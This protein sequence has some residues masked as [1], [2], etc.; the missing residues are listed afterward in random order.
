MQT[1][2]SFPFGMKHPQAQPVSCSSRCAPDSRVC[3]TIS[4][5]A[6]CCEFAGCA[7]V[8]HM[9]ISSI[10]GWLAKPFLPPSSPAAFC[11]SLRH[12]N[13]RCP[14]LDLPLT[15][16]ACRVRSS[17]LLFPW[18]VC[19][20]VSVSPSLVKAELPPLPHWP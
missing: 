4:F 9:V 2:Q 16:P 7:R 12:L 8:R 15:G 1:V 10:H 14:L 3:K 13:P 18:M 6:R 11:A 20:C 17:A 5:F 19:Q